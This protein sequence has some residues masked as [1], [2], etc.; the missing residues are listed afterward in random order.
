VRTAVGYS[1]EPRYKPALTVSAAMS[2]NL[3]NYAAAGEHGREKLELPWLGEE[4]SMLRAR[5]V[6]PTIPVKDLEKAE[7][8][9]RDKLGLEPVREAFDGAWYRIGDRD[10]LI[11]PSGFAGTNQGTAAEFVVDDVPAAVGVLRERGVVFEDYD[12]P[13]FK[14]VDGVATFEGPQQTA[15]FRDV[16]GNI[17]ALTSLPSSV[18]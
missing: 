16:D 15:W 9:F 11:Y 4:H 18:S 8:F 12:F 5:S 2:L 6:H 7:R 13:D 14:T 1:G 10:L 17:L 3:R